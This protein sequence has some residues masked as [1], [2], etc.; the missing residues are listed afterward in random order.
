[1]TYPVEVRDAESF[2]EV[3]DALLA[4]GYRRVWLGD[5]A[6]D[7]DEVRPSDVL[8]ARA[9]RA[10][11]KR[12]PQNAPGAV[13]DVIA[14][15]TVAA[16]EER[17]RLLEALEAAMSRS[18]GRA[19]VRVEDGPRLRFGGGLH[20]AYCDRSFRDPVPAMF[21]FNNPLGACETCHGFGRI[22]DIDFD[23]VV[24]DPSRTLAGGAIQPW[25][26]ASTAWEREQLARWCR[27][28]G[29]PMN[30]PWSRL[31]PEDRA[32]VLEGDGVG[33]PDGWWGVR[34]WFEWLESRA[35]KL[36]VRVLLSRYRAQVTCRD[37]GGT[38]LRPEALVW[39]LAG[40]T[41]PAWMALPI[42]RALEVIE[43]EQ[44]SRRADPAV[45]LLL[46]EIAR[47]LRTL[48]DVGLG[49]LTLD[50]PS[51][52]LSGGESQRVALASAMGASL[53]GALFVVDEPTVGLHPADVARL[54]GVVRRLARAGNLVVVVEHDEGV[55]GAADRV[56]E[57]GPGAGERGGRIVFDGTPAQLARADTAT[58]R[59]LRR[60]AVSRVRRRKAR[61]WLELTGAR[62]NNLRG[63]ELRI[64]LGALTVVTGPSGSGKSSLVVDTLVPAVRRHLELGAEPPLPFEGLRG[65]DGLPDAIHV[66]QAPLARTSR[67]NAA[68]YLGVWDAFRARLAAEPLARQRGW[69][70][71][72]FSFNVPGGRCEACRGEGAETVEMQFLADVTFTCPECGG[73]RFV[74]AVLD[75]R[76]RGYNVAQLLETSAT[77]LLEHFADD[78]EIARGLKRLQDVGLGY[79]RLGQSLSTLS[80]G[81]AQ[82]L[83]LAEALIRAP[84]GAL[85]VL[86]EPTA[87]LH[88]KDVEPLLGL[89]ERLLADGSTVVV[90]EHDMRLAAH[91]DWI[92]DLGPG[93]GD[94]GGRIVAVGTPEQVARSQ[95]RTAPHLAAELGLV[96]RQPSELAS[97]TEH[98]GAPVDEEYDPD[99]IVVQ[100]AREH[101]LHDVTVRIP[102]GRLVVVTGPSGSGKSTLA[103]D[104]VY[105][106]GQ[107]RYLETLSPYARQYLPQLPRP[108]V[109]RVV[110][111]P[112]C[113]SLEQRSTHGGGHSTV[114]TLT[115][116]AHDLRLVWARAG[117]PHCPE[118]AEPIAPRSPAQVARDVAN[119]YG[120][121]GV[122]V[123]APVVRGRKGHYR[124]LFEKLR[125]EGFEEVRVDGSF[126]T[127]ERGMQ[128]DRYR[129]HDVD[130]VVG[131]ARGADPRIEELLRSA[132]ARA[133]GIA[134][135]LVRSRGVEM[136]VSER[137]ACPSCG[138]GV[139]DLDPRFFSFH[140]RQGA[141][142]ACGGLGR[143]FEAPDAAVCE[144]CGGSRLSSLARAVTVGGV[145][146]DEVLRLSVT[147]ARARLASLRLNA[148]EREIA[149]VPLAEAD[150][151]LAFL[152]QV[153]VGYLTLDR[154][155]WTLSGGEMQRVRLAAQLGAGL[156]G[157]LYVLDEP[158]IGLHPRDTARLIGALRG[159]V[160]RGNSVLVVEHDAETIRAAD[161]VIDVGPGGGR[162]GGHV[163]A[164]GPP[165]T[166]L[167]E[168]TSVTGAA[169]ARP[170][171][172][173][174]RRR[175]VDGQPSLVL[176]GAR[177]HNLQDVTLRLPLG[178]LVVVTGVSGSGKSTLVR[179][180]LLRA[181]QRRLGVA[182]VEPPGA[183]DAL[184]GWEPLRRAVEID[185]SPIGRTPRSVP[186][187]Y[188]GV[189]DAIRR[190]LASTP[191]ARARG[192]DASRFS[193]NVRGG[194][195]E[196]CEG[197]GS[198]AV[199][200][201][202]LPTMHVSCE[203]CGGRR[204]ERETLGVRLHGLNAAQILDLE[205]AEAL[206][207]FGAVPEI[208][209]PLRLLDALGLGYLRL[210]QP[211]HTL[212]GGEAQRLKLVAELS[213]T[214][215][216]RTLYVMDE[217]TTGLHRDDVARLLGVLESLVDRGD[218]V[219]VIEHH[220]DVMLAADW[221]VDLGPEGGRDGGRIVAEGT[222]EQLA[223]A[224]THT[225]KVLATELARTGAC[226]EAGTSRLARIASPSSVEGMP[227]S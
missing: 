58:G 140:T 70:P 131:R 52:T 217:P 169:L 189:W 7:L 90:V 176:R 206:E 3:R 211:S 161:H 45:S 12:R 127:V 69:K 182:G 100:G 20:C 66:D 221:I 194:R 86:D 91:A 61:G 143:V 25:T 171:R 147:D 199:E 62:G 193:F 190:W 123:L 213:T 19:E 17:D 172:V 94:D 150:R 200:M 178:R 1:M 29:V 89:F 167:D 46:R 160:E 75:V 85:V 83:K 133:E 11:R 53:S 119:R 166:L 8:G 192:W 108:D 14:D 170:P 87:G 9:S 23:R 13:L 142:E 55:I 196:A 177:A 135:L 24:P 122:T 154:S 118:C 109:D 38:R 126:R 107:R 145:R 95:S 184:E 132:F 148:R 162:R 99:A 151:R 93:G 110:G 120:S 112:P 156:T 57:L 5:E 68:T 186:A 155:G 54:A 219:V 111:L 144:A 102:R 44:P 22:L 30:V 130:V 164:E 146:I 67:G 165:S 223:R 92:V 139:P 81:E 76:H 10:G 78:E 77:D 197:R 33:W 188:V 116:V 183:H 82:R 225:G 191:E 51:R 216:K 47:R 101:N 37:C 21:S 72:M 115:E 39:R 227:S 180:V 6:R 88:P 204:F 174:E 210:G 202:F 104:V 203:V 214:G 2:L 113:V 168:P 36:H 158:T 138:R 124:E 173:P 209:R 43:A 64:P 80:G 179:D 96:P 198:T 27:R 18:G 175:P 97:P 153:G 34:G 63:V 74:G 207:R 187:T 73:R 136:L 129:E 84:R 134:R 201:A 41:L 185:Q 195:C 181:V 31:S 79:L 159:L 157:V 220:P 15:R 26:T 128:L 32:W 224:V 106:E 163:V 71:S 49:Y 141:C 208:A 65:A 226:V 215:A 50:R 149:R 152:E 105:A 222:P 35:Y 117:T 103:F 28:R 59:A 42:G 98:R 121:D 125:K 4:D 56:V 48:C 40:L 60:E 212:S 218:S 137:R 205:V 16:S 114:G